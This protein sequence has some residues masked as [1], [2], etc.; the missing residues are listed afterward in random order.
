MSTSAFIVKTVT[1]TAARELLSAVRRVVFLEEQKVPPELEWDGADDGACHVLAVAEDGTPVGTARLKLDCRIGRMAVVKSWRRR[2]VGSQMLSVLIGI[3]RKEGC[4]TVRLH[5]QT[6]AVDFY[7]R[8]GF[9]AV[10]AEFEEAGITHRAM[11]LTV[12]T[13]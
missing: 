3:A 1:W 5:A 9:T 2:G 4:T 7:R 12:H 13:P 11:E 10:G 8:H 6:Q